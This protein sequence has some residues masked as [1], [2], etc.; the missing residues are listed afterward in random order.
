MLRTLVRSHNTTLQIFVNISPKLKKSPNKKTGKR[1]I[2][3][4]ILNEI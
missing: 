1:N 3:Q 2:T 4:L